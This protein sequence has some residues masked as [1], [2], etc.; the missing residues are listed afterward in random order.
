MTDNSFDYD[1]SKDH[2]SRL[3]FIVDYLNAT[4]DAHEHTT[5][6]RLIRKQAELE[7]YGIWDDEAEYEYCNE[8]L[9][10]LEMREIMNAQAVLLLWAFVEKL[11]EGY[12]KAIEG[13]NKNNT[14]LFE[15]FSFRLKKRSKPFP[16]LVSL[17]KMYFH[18][19]REPPQGL[20][21]KD[22]AYL[23]NVLHI[24]NFIAHNQH[25]PG[26]KPEKK[27][28]VAAKA[29]E[30]IEVTSEGIRVRYKFLQTLVY[31]SSALLE[32]LKGEHWVTRLSLIL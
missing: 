19:L 17:W 24:R 16:S 5:D 20:T 8:Q 1:F 30:D 7:S 22:W 11:I 29:L 4:Q 14:E 2:E 21:D 10:C 26:F 28:L 6:Q 25:N 23:Q 15:D 27:Q 18:T 31:Q 9:A 32:K 12:I 3:R 13:K